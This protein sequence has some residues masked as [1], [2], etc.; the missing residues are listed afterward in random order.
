MPCRLPLVEIASSVRA[1]AIIPQ[2]V[3]SCRAAGRLATRVGQVNGTAEEMSDT[4]KRCVRRS[5]R[6]RDVRCAAAA[7]ETAD[8]DGS[9][10]W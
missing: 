10:R 9:L 1:S 7:E 3:L 2:R 4:G 8:S 6:R 5:S